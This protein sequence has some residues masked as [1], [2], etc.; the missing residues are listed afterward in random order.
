MPSRPPVVVNGVNLVQR[1]NPY[2]SNTTAWVDEGTASYHALNVSLLKRV[3]HGLT[4]K[5]N[6]SFVKVMDLNSAV[7]APSRENEP[8]DVYSPYNLGM[9]RGPAAY[10]I[11]HQ[12][13]ANFSYQLPFGSGHRFN[14]GGRLMNQLIG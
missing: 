3:T 13:N 6:Y 9:N 4:F 14:G 10:S 1:P 12:F 7:L 5:A 8:A 2:V 11:H